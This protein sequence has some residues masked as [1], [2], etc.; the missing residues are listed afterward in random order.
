[1]NVLS[2]VF[3][4]ARTEW[5]WCKGNPVREIKRPPDGPPRDRRISPEEEKRLLDALGYA[6]KQPQR[7]QKHE[8]AY[9]FLIALETAMRC[10]EILTLTL[11]RVH[12]K[13][14]YVR[15]LKTK[16]GTARQVALSNRAVQLLG[17]L[18]K[19]AREKKRNKLFTVSSSNADTLFRRARDRLPIVDL[20]FHET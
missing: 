3:E 2:S 9:A 20:C 12:L 10:G 1:M 7:L 5:K 6:E 19:I 11:E 4:I 14:R 15:L 17:I 13:E 16:N 8:V 18:A